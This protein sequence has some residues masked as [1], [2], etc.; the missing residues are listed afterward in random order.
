M[1]LRPLSFKESIAEKDANSLYEAEFADRKGNPDL[2]V[3]V[4]A[5]TAEDVSDVVLQHFAYAPFD[6][7]GLTHTVDLRPVYPNPR[8][9]P[10]DAPFALIRNAHHVLDFADE[11]AVRA[12][13]QAVLDGVASKACQVFSRE[14]NKL[15]ARLAALREDPEWQAFLMRL[16][17]S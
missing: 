17:R 13:A 7:P 10:T 15:R 12:F 11:A 16:E 14:K 9:D 4:Y 2:E 5:A 3:S 6:P 1:L 8:H